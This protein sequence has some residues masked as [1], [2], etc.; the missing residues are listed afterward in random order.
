MAEMS[1]ILIAGATDAIRE[2][3][4]TV[5]GAEGIS[6][7]AVPDAA[8]ALKRATDFQLAIVD[9]SL[10]GAGFLHQLSATAPGGMLPVLAIG[11]SDASERALLL[12]EGAD[13]CMPWPPSPEELLARVRSLLRL[14]GRFEALGVKQRELEQLSRTDSLTGLLNHKSIKERI[15]EEF[16]RA[17]RHGDPLGVL[18][19]DLDHFKLLNDRRGH[20]FGDRVLL[21]V[22]AALTEAVRETDLCGRYGGEEFAVVLPRT[23]LNGALTVAERIRASVE[24]ADFDG[25]RMTLSVGVAGF[26]GSASNPE[27]LLRAADE[28]L[29]ANKR[30]GRNRTQIYR[31]A[32]RRASVRIISTDRN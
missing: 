17:Q 18:M 23:S 3:V 29:Y 26:P 31:D 15:T 6:V 13:D 10:A 7:E 28:A 25:E 11:A 9:R 14:R 21:R 5:L 24:L 16:R 2:R 30:E 19:V 32:S 22:A 20:P 27:L 12:D 4:Q 1:R 8:A